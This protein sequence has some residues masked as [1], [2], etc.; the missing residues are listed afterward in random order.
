MCYL[1]K[2][3]IF[4]TLTILLM[5]ATIVSAQAAE[6]FK[7]RATN[8]EFTIGGNYVDEAT[9]DFDGGTQLESNSTSGIILGLGYN[10]TDKLATNVQLGWNSINYTAERMLD[11][12]STQTVAGT[13]DYSVIQLNVMYHFLKGAVSPYV[14]GGLGRTFIDTN[15][16]SGP[17]V[18][19]CWYDPWWGYVCG[20]YQ[21]T[22]SD[23]FTSFNV[24]VGM[25]WDI[26]Q[27]IFLR[28]GIG[29]HRINADNTS[30]VDFDT[31]RLEVGFS[32]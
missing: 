30:E 16:P 17:P 21:P 27:K 15:I 26:N 9:I 19:T 14:V 2:F 23:S 6:P 12:G 11:T 5:M 24:G 18:G 28:V 31:T 4:S 7:G 25:R 32:Y 3:A 1:R 13:V 20:E 22:Q 10:Y 8:W 29:R